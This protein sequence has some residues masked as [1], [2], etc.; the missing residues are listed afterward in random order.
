M[1]VYAC[2]NGGEVVVLVWMTMASK[3][4]RVQQREHSI[5]YGVDSDKAGN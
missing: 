5:F 2:P 4:Y 3:G 1:V